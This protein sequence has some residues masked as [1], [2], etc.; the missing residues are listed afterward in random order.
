MMEPFDKVYEIHNKQCKKQSATTS[1]AL[2]FWKGM[3][4]RRKRNLLQELV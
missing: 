4:W 2:G 1:Q 3:K